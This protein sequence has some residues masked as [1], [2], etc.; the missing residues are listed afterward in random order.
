MSYFNRRFIQS[1]LLAIGLTL[2]GLSAEQPQSG[3]SVFLTNGPVGAAVYIDGT[4]I[5]S[6]PSSG[7]FSIERL[8]EGPLHL[9]VVADG[10]TI[11]DRN[12]TFAETSALTISLGVESPAPVTAP[13]KA[14]PREDRPQPETATPQATENRT[15][16]PAPADLSTNSG[17]TA[18]GEDGTGQPPRM[19]IARLDPVDS[20]T[21]SDISF[22]GPV[23]LLAVLLP[24]GF[25]VFYLLW[26]R[27]ARAADDRRDET[28]PPPSPADAARQESFMN[29]DGESDEIARVP[30]PPTKGQPDFLDELHHKEALFSRGFR[31]MKDKKDQDQVVLDLTDYRVG[32]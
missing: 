28:S 21:S 14:P 12:I 13:P 22:I 30:H 15:R 20:E 23:L 6:I 32:E 9:V 16:R 8:P 10:V 26:R 25:I 17:A 31:S 18:R 11:Y 1:V 3:G 7:R 4:W 2:G 29:E 19:E 27:H 5:G 24:L